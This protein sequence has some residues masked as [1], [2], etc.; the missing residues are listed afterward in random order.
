VNR[1]T[2]RLALRITRLAKELHVIEPQRVCV[3]DMFGDDER[4]LDLGGGGEG[5]IGQLRGQQ[6]VAVDIRKEELDEAPAGPVKVV[7]DARALPF[8]DSSFDAA[9]AFFFLMYVSATDR[10]AVLREAHRVLRPRGTLRIWDATIPASGPQARR[11]FAV[12]VRADLP[13]RTVRT[14]YGVQWEGHEMSSDAIAQAAKE[15]GFSLARAEQAGGSFFL[16]LVRPPL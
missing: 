14:L 13:D 15:A 8:P 11:T 7:A 3:K 9:T 4:I 6:V 12:P 1:L 5:V 2:W 10:A 16:T